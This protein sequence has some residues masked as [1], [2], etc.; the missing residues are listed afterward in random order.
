MGLGMHIPG[1]PEASD[2]TTALGVVQAEQPALFGAVLLFIS[3]AEGE[4]VGHSGDNWRGMSTK[5]AGNLG[6]DVSRITN[7][8]YTSFCP[9]PDLT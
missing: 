7:F 8:L 9:D 6:F 2:W 5:E 3:L 4:S 1:M